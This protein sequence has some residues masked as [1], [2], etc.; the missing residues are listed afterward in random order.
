MQHCF[1]QPAAQLSA[2]QGRSGDA[3]AAAESPGGGAPTSATAAQPRARAAAAADNVGLA[4]A[5]GCSRAERKTTGSQLAAGGPPEL[6]AEFSSGVLA[7]GFGPC[8]C[9]SRC[10][11]RHE[12]G[13]CSQPCD[14]G[15]KAELCQSCLC[16]ASPCSVQ[17]FRGLYCY[18]HGY[19]H[20]PAETQLMRAFGLAG[21]LQQMMPADIK[22]YLA[23]EPHLF[24]DWAFDL[25]AAWFKEPLA[26]SLLV[27]AKPA[28]D[29]YSSAD[30]EQSLH[31]VLGAQP[32]KH[33]VPYAPAVI[34]LE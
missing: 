21:L 8:Q 2:G 31:A 29:D 7:R 6:V 5:G 3:L 11:S 23:A 16:S 9:S 25:L 26:I 10:G 12:P 14:V 17:R 13:A 4:V 22:A 19:C 24:G 1:C 33:R 18:A 30:F 28:G 34:L 15:I 20:M 27:A 32:P